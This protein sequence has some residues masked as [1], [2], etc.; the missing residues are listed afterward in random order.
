MLQFELKG[1]G[2][3]TN[4]LNALLEQNFSGYKKREEYRYKTDD[5]G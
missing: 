3:I 5:D 4:S 2:G 1:L